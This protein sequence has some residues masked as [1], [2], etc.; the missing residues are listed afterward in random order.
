MATI[1]SQSDL[2]SNSGVHQKFPKIGGFTI[3]ESL[4]EGAQCSIYRA[5]Q[6]RL[7]RS[8]ALK[9]LPEW[10]PPSDV[11]LE[12]FNRAAYVMAQ[13]PHSGLC[14]LFDTGARDGYYFASMELVAGRT[15]QQQLAQSAC[16][17]EGFAISVGLQILRTLSVLHAKE[18]CHRNVKPKN[19][20]IEPNGKSRLIG[21]GLSNCKSAFFS[22]HLDSHAIGTPHF[23]AP[24]MIR[25]N[26]ADPRSDLY[27]VGVSL[28]LMVAGRPPFEAGIP[29]AVM[30]RHLTEMPKELGQLRPDLSPEFVKLVHK[31]LARDPAH[32]YSSAYEAVVVLESLSQ[33]HKRNFDGSV[34]TPSKSPTFPPLNFDPESNVSG[35]SRTHSRSL[36]PAIVASV[37]AIG[38]VLVIGLLAFGIY[39]LFGINGTNSKPSSNIPVP[40]PTPIDTSKERE[41]KELPIDPTSAEAIE[42]A[43]LEAQE[44]SFQT[45]PDD[46]VDAWAEYSMHFPKA[47]PILLKKSRENLDR[48]L[49]K[50]KANILLRRQNATPV[51]P[52]PSI[53]PRRKPIQADDMEF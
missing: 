26:C 2:S 4:Y 7:G 6:D 17:D 8:V 19:I 32:R 29:A 50:I 22:P 38:T 36:H 5:R 31:L 27:S 15:L 47:N 9:L 40:T 20:F 44:T 16:T 53:E 48:F 46:G 45:H 33:K 42:V 21:L 28:Y 18:I 30:T 39:S 24:E 1:H 35:Q 23:M 49:L 3:L 14:T 43:R 37:S 34:Q 10:P 52:A 25:G 12:R 11:A 41:L 13:A 51:V